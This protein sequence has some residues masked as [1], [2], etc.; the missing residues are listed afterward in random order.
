MNEPSGADL[1]PAEQVSEEHGAA[2]LDGW[3]GLPPA[4]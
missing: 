4:V 1:S 3:L 2:M